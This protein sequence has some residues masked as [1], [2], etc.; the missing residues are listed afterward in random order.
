MITKLLNKAI[1]DLM[2]NYRHR[3][4]IP[5]TAMHWND[6]YYDYGLESDIRHK[7]NFKPIG[8]FY[9]EQQHIVVYTSKLGFL[10]YFYIM[11]HKHIVHI[12]THPEL[13]I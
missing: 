13:F 5:I 2:T 9:P 11:P 1:T 12:S 7:P 3:T 8:F 10:F 6:W 4:G